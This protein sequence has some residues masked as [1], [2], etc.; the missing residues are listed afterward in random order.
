MFLAASGIGSAANTRVGHELGAGRGDRAKL[1]FRTAITAVLLLQGSIT[2]VIWFCRQ[3][4]LDVFT[5]SDVITTATLAVMPVLVIT[6]VTD[7]VNNVLGGVMRGAGKQHAGAVLNLVGYWLLGLPLALLLGM[8]YDL[9]AL[10]FWMGLLA[11]SCF[12]IVALL[13]VILRMDWQKEAERA[14]KEAMDEM[15][16][17]EAFVADASWIVEE[18]DE[19]GADE[20]VLQASGA[21]A[22]GGLRQPL[23]GS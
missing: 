18:G 2:A 13:T 15:A 21:A 8:R 19:E 5:D 6:L 16:A 14:R 4:V 23:L 3:G 9:G 11:A 10:G 12:Q 22:T 20:E 17:W 1:V 7:S